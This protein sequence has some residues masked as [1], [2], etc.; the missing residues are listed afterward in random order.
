MQ[1]IFKFRMASGSSGS[2]IDDILRNRA[3]LE[4]HFG[5]HLDSDESDLD[6]VCHDTNR[7]FLRL[8]GP[9]ASLHLLAIAPVLLSLQS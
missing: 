6:S 3:D 9:I 7:Y 5:I 2:A 4:A 1:E 8:K